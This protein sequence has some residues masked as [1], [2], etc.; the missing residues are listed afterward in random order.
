MPL[1]DSEQHKLVEQRSLVV[2]AGQ[3]SS[4]EVEARDL[5]LEPFVVVV[6]PLLV[7]VQLLAEGRRASNSSS[8]LA[9]LKICK[10]LLFQCKRPA[11][12]RR[13]WQLDRT[14]RSI[15][16]HTSNPNNHNCSSF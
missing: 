12:R 4:A 11:R 15:C 2:V 5:Q 16:T 1:P 7:A 6:V 10:L 14:F 8:F 13:K 3:R 9:A